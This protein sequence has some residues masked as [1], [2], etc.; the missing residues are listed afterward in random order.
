MERRSFLKGLVV[1]MGTA[2]ST[3]LVK[4]ASPEEAQALVHQPV[5]ILAQPPKP[6][7]TYDLALQVFRAGNPIFASVGS[8]Q[9][10]PIGY[11]T[12]I[13]VEAPVYSD[14]TVHGDA[15]VSFNPSGLTRGKMD[16][17]F[18]FP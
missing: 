4:L 13:N 3:A 8:N 17:E 6:R 16:L 11:I 7:S 18:F 9:F 10:V 5:G 12:S 1:G 15:A 14:I 2:A